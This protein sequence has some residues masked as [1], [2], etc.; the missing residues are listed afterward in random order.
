ME[1]LVSG[2]N[3]EALVIYFMNEFINDLLGGQDSGRSLSLAMAYVPP[4][5]FEDVYDADVAIS[6]GTIFAKLDFP[7]MG[8][9]IKDEVGE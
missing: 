7:F 4:Q 3:P 1:R 5:E 2:F 8:R 9:T 6:R